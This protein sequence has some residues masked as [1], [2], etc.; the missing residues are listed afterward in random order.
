MASPL[1]TMASGPREVI[2][3]NS[4]RG[5]RESAGWA[6]RGV[7]VVSSH[8]ALR[9]CTRLVHLEAVELRGDL[10]DRASVGGV[11][12]HRSGVAHH[13]PERQAAEVGRRRSGGKA[14]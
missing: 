13:I 7:R 10:E 4:A 2:P 14:R 11:H 12:V 1:A 3:E 8:P 6:L 5:T 9:T